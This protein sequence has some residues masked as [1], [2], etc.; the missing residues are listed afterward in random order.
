MWDNES[1]PVGCWLFSLLWATSVSACIGIHR[2]WAPALL[3][4]GEPVSVALAWGKKYV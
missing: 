3:L 4:G 1:Q 2:D